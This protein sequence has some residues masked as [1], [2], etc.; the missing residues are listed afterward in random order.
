MPEMTIPSDGKRHGNG[1]ASGRHK[2]EKMDERRSDARAKDLRDGNVRPVNHT[3]GQI[4]YESI[5]PPLNA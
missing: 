1:C 2:R 5:W 3:E 4:Y